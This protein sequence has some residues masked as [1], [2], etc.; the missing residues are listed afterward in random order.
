[1][2]DRLFFVHVMKTG[3]TTLRH[4]LVAQFQASELYPNP[5]LDTDAFVAYSDVKYLLSLPEHRTRLI[6]AYSGHF[7]YAVVQRMTGRFVTLTVLREP[8]DRTISYLRQCRNV[9]AQYRDLPLEQIYEDPWQYPFAIA[10]YQSRI[11]GLTPDDEWLSVMNAIEI[12]ER[13]LAI[14]KVNLEN[15]DVLGMHDE[16]DEFEAR[17]SE[18]FGWPSSPWGRRRVGGG[19][20]APESLRRRIAVDNAADVEF[21]E[22]A[23]ELYERRR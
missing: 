23:R 19:G 22:Y 2:T 14:A 13:R 5:E 17:V 11:F 21:F 8:V 18:R 6:R 16:Y 12:D 3:G 15:I 10:N 4:A 1:V 7:P 9:I 20:D